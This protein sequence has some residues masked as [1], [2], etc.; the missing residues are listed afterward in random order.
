MGHR[1]GFT[2]LCIKVFEPILKND[3]SSP[4]K[5]GFPDSFDNL[6]VLAILSL[7]SSWKKEL[8]SETA[9]VWSWGVHLWFPLP[10]PSTVSLLAFEMGTH[11]P[12]WQGSGGRWGWQELPHSGPQTSCWGPRSMSWGTREL[13][14]ALCGRMTWNLCFRE[15]PSLDP[16]DT[17]N[18]IWGS[19][20]SS[21]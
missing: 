8:D 11:D 7:Y 14:K 19:D 18:Q 17:P 1:W 15:P 3:R 12:V 21:F 5:S 6:E 13:L 2:G 9:Q 4:K 20:R 16:T 10:A